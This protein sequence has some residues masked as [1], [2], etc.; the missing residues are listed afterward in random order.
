MWQKELLDEL[1]VVDGGEVV[2]RTEAGVQPHAEQEHEERGEVLLS[3]G[4]GRETYHDLLL[5]LLLVLWVECVH[6][7]AL[8][9]LLRG[10][11]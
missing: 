7:R 3:V 1:V 6:E 11:C 2:V 9:R 4:D 8:L 10:A 5:V